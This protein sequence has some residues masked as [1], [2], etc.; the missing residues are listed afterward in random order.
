MAASISILKNA[1]HSGCHL[2]YSCQM[3]LTDLWLV[4]LETATGVLHSL[5]KS[6]PAFWGSDALNQ[7][8]D[9]YMNH[10]KINSGH[11]KAP[12]SSLM[13][14]ITKKVPTKILLPTLVDIWLVTASNPNLVRFSRPWLG[15]YL[16]KRYSI[17]CQLI[18]KSCQGRFIMHL[19]L[20]SSSIPGVC[21][22]SSFRPLISSKWLIH[23]RAR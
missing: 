7:T 20:L 5:L 19:E 9:L 4:L 14:S 22:T 11:P 16:I 1:D 18:W 17:N 15:I 3:D 10:C 13:K 2:N 21:R 8:V 12:L 6:I 23:P